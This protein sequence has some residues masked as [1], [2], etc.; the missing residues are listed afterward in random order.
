MVQRNPWQHEAVRRRPG[1]AFAIAETGDV[2]PQDMWKKREGN[3]S[4]EAITA[5][6]KH[7][8]GRGVARFGV[9]ESTVFTWDPAARRAIREAGWNYRPK[10]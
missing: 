5:L 2:N 3:L 1:Q 9:Y 10:P 6:A 4:P 7:Y 8:S